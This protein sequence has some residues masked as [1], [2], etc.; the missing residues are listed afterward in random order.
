[1]TKPRKTQRR[2]NRNGGRLNFPPVPRPSQL[3]Y[4]GIIPANAAEEGIVSVLR[5]VATYS[6]GAG[7][8][9]VS[10]LD[11]NP[12]STDNWSEYS[13]SWSEYRV[14]GVRFEY[15][16]TFTVNTAAINSAPLAHSVLHMKATPAISS[17]PQA[18]SYG[19]ARLGHVN[20]RFTRE[21]RMAS[22][23]EGTFIDT[24]SPAGTAFVFTA[25]AEGLTA[26]L[27]YGTLFRTWLIQFRNPRK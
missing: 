8:S 9:F 19:D 13:T 6:T 24:A 7:T 25:Y 20:K 2:R 10:Y 12:S 3:E 16:P 11:N 23:E 27:T 4:K 18:L 14:L 21:W 17:Y 1:M 15:V 5:D 22:A 26:A